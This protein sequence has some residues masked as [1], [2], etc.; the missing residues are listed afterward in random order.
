MYR[1]HIPSFTQTGQQIWKE[2]TDIRLLPSVNYWLLINQF[3]Q[4][5][6]L[7]DNF[8]K[9]LVQLLL[10]GQRWTEKGQRVST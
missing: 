4:N 10:L 8:C 1:C 7:L 9:E 6:R 2:L 5:S 3:L